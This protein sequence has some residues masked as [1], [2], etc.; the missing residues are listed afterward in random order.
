MKNDAFFNLAEHKI[1]FFDIKTS[2]LAFLLHF[3]VIDNQIPL[4]FNYYDTRSHADLKM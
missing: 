2:F 3:K 4:H 1:D